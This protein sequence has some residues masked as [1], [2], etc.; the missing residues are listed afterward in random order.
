MNFD[1]IFSYDNKFFQFMNRLVDCVCLSLLFVLFSL[2][3]VTLGASATALYYTVNK[4]I[5]GGRGYV[6]RSFLESFRSNFKQSTVLWLVCILIGALLVL[7]AVITRQMMTANSPAGMLYYVFLLLILFLV[8]WACYLFAYTARFANTTKEIL[9][10]CAF[11]MIAHLP[12][13]LVIA[14]ILGVMAFLAW[15]FVPLFFVLPSFA[16]MFVHPVFESIVR[17]Y[18]QPEDLEREKELEM[19]AKR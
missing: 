3:V 1:R 15:Y 11:I 9:K 19:E 14:V 4:V 10:N 6:F 18:M 13:T 8:L 5:I 7:D 2:P 17:K 16:T 12:K